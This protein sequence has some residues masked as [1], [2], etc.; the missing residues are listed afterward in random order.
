MFQV[1]I[2]R[3]R[4][5]NPNFTSSSTIYPHDKKDVRQLGS[6]FGGVLMS[7]DVNGDKKDDLFVG[8]PLYTA[9]SYDEGR[10]FVYLSSEQNN[11]IWVNEIS[12]C[13]FVYHIYIYI[14][15][16]AIVPVVRAFF[17]KKLL[18]QQLVIEL[19]FELPALRGKC[20]STTKTATMQGNYFKK[21]YKK[22]KKRVKLGKT[23]IQLFVLLA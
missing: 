3:P 20:I 4:L 13:T 19:A 6:Y 12:F 15:V 5:N 21:F 7:T 11:I 18:H 17:K 16:N 22:P 1:V 2:Y 8:A 14:Y 23:R 9:S 10:V